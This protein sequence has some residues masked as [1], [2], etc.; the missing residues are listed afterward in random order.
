MIAIANQPHRQ[1]QYSVLASSVSGNATGHSSACA[2]ELSPSSGPRREPNLFKETV[3]NC[4][5]PSAVWSTASRLPWLFPVRSRR[6][7]VAQVRAGRA[8]R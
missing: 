6:F 1:G 2:A 4:L 3:A 7:A 8:G 5:V